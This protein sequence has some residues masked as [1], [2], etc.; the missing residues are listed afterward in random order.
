MSGAVT[1]GPALHDAMPG[2]VLAIHGPDPW[3]ATDQVRG[4]KATA[5][6]V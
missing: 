2:L 4:L 5:I 1:D 3:M 6:D